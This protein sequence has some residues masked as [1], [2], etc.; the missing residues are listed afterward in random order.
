MNLLQNL[1]YRWERFS[2]GERGIVLKVEP[3][4]T[5]VIVGETKQFH[6]VIAF[7]VEKQ[8][9]HWGIGAV[10]IDNHF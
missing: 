1:G 6:P 4:P 2:Q 5:L 9:Q 10:T 7:A 3:A 8:L